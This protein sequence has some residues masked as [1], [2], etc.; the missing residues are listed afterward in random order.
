[1][2][3]ANRR[4][5]VKLTGMA[6]L[7]LGSSGLLGSCSSSPKD[8]GE[9]VPQ[10]TANND[11][12]DD[13]QLSIIGPYG[14]WA[15]ALIQSE[16]PRLSYRRKE[17]TDINAWRKVARQSVIDR[18]AAPQIGGIPKVT[19]REKLIYDGL[20]IEKISWQLPYG[21]PTEAVVIKPANATGPLPGILAFHDH[22]MDKFHG[23]V[24]LIQTSADRDPLMEAHQ[25]EYYSGRGWA[26][27][28]AKRGYVVMIS[29][30]F[31]F[32][33]RR[34]KLSDVP[35]VLRNGLDASND[36]SPEHITAYNKWAAEH[37]H[38][39]SKSLLSA[40]T[41]WPG[42][43][44]AEDQKALDILCSR[45][46][47]DADR[48]GCAGL[49][50]GGVRTH[51]M[52]AM[53]TRIKCAVPVG[54]TTTWKDMVMYQSFTHTWMAF[55]PSISRD[56]DFPEII[57]TRVPM[58]ILILNNSEDPLFTL[59][60]MKEADTVLRDVYKKA[61]VEDHYKCSFYPGLHKFEKDMQEEAFDWFDKWLKA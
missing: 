44:F 17:F 51:Y 42:V 61:H 6:G 24:K 45:K 25:K 47:V 37:E 46:D 34:V 7:A 52:A 15:A 31:A 57:G 5:F 41:T 14:P 9:N 60:E 29:D 2:R 58:P 27:E 12:M 23:H 4:T 20:Q 53:D 22:G 26:N 43:F 19:V 48:I 36:A 56:L 11:N 50:G 54:F 8:S 59:S 30:A 49:S 13:K 28:I 39:I 40:G 32:A 55:V 18:L 3:K 16:L 38:V 35:E 21:R 33:S 1:M 10:G